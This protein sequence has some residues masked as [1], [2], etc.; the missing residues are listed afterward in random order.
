ML[1]DSEAEAKSAIG[2]STNDE[3]KVRMIYAKKSRYNS[4]T[5]KNRKLSNGKTS[6][7]VQV[8]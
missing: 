5:V 8:S 1:Y 4:V 2:E 7:K 3:V 6:G